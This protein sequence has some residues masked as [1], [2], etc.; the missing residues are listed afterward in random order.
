MYVCCAFVHYVCP[1]DSV[2]PQD[3]YHVLFKCPK[4][5]ELRLQYGLNN[6]NDNWNYLFN[7]ANQGQSMKLIHNT[8]KLYDH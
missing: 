5:N 4:T 2:T 6:S 8:L 7:N 3:E 1:C